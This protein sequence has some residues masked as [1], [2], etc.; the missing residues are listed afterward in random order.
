MRSKQNELDVDFIG[1]QPALTKDEEN[2]IS[3]YIKAYK[4]KRK[5]ARPS[6]SLKT[7][8]LKQVKPIA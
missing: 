5:N 6:V 3:E 8:S 2:A 7:R 4:N 1:G